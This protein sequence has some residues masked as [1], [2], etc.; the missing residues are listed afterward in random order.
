MLGSQ[1]RYDKT[2]K[3]PRDMPAQR[4]AAKSNQYANTHSISP[5]TNNLNNFLA[6]PSHRSPA[7]RDLKFSAV[8][9]TIS[10]RSSKVIL[11]AAPPIDMSINTARIH[12]CT[13]NVGRKV[14]GPFCCSGSGKLHQFPI[15]FALTATVRCSKFATISFTWG[16]TSSGLISRLFCRNLPSSP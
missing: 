11:A 5:R 13:S 16:V 4:V 2:W 9:G 12:A 7:Q 3:N 6:S 8:R 10:F 1:P 15:G 14:E